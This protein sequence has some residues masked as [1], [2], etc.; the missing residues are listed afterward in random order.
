MKKP[1]QKRAK[2]ITMEKFK[3]GSAAINLGF[4]AKPIQGVVKQWRG[5]LPDVSI[6]HVFCVAAMHYR[7]KFELSV[8]DRL[9]EKALQW[10]MLTAAHEIYNDRES[11]VYWLLTMEISAA[12]NCR[13][14]P[15][16]TFAMKIQ[17]RSGIA[18]QVNALKKAAKRLELPLSQEI[19]RFLRASHS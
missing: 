11:P 3:A 19:K 4:Y 6:E 13:L 5:K 16:K 12:V 10:E 8:P 15:W 1:K 17:K 18:F 9:E 14:D 7:H 2:K